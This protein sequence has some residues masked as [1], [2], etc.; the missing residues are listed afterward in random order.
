M[1]A[2]AA[3]PAAQ[4]AAAPQTPGRAA[5]FVQLPGGGVSFDPLAIPLPPELAP[6][7]YSWLRRLALQADLAGADRLLRDALADLTSSL[8]GRPHLSRPDGLHSL[9]ADDELPQDQPA[10]PRGRDARAARWRHR[11]S[12]SCRSRRRPRRSR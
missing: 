5:P 11:T 4:Y 1:H 3:A 6:H 10:D 8:V 7:V 2:A 12:R 9:G